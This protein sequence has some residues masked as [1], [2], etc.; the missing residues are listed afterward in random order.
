MLSL[1]FQQI[2]ASAE[3]HK[4]IICTIYNS[5]FFFVFFFTSGGDIVCRLVKEIIKRANLMCISFSVKHPHTF[6]EL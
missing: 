5:V 4:T 1:D 2:K 3:V 6:G